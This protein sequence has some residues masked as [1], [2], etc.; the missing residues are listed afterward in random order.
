[1]AVIKLLFFIF[2]MSHE[3]FELD[4][5]NCIFKVSN[6]SA[7]SYFDLS[8]LSR[9]V[10]NIKVAD[11][12]KLDGSRNSRGGNRTLFAFMSPCSSVKSRSNVDYCPD[13]SASVCI[14][15]KSGGVWSR[16]LP[17]LGTDV[18]NK[19]SFANGTLK[20][21]LN[22]KEKCVNDKNYE[23]EILFSCVEKFDGPLMARLSDCS[24][25]VYW[26]TKIACPLKGPD[27]VLVDRCLLQTE[28]ENSGVV[29]LRPLRHPQYYSVHSPD[30]GLFYLN[31]CAT[32][33]NSTC[34]GSTACKHTKNGTVVIIGST[35][36]TNVRIADDGP[37]LVYKAK[38][39]IL[40]RVEFVCNVSVPFGE[41]TFRSEVGNTYTF[42]FQSSHACPK[43]IVDCVVY[44]D[45]ANKFD[46]SNLRRE[47]GNWEVR[48][49]VHGRMNSTFFINVCK[50]LNPVRMC[51]F[52]DGPVGV[53]QT[54]DAGTAI[55]LGMVIKGP[56]VTNGMLQISY[57][58]GSL[59]PNGEGRYRTII[60]FQCTNTKGAPIFESQSADCVTSFIWPTNIA[61]PMKVAKGENCM[62]VEP[63]YSHQFDMTSLHNSKADYVVQT[64][65]GSFRINLCGSLVAPCDNKENISVCLEKEDKQQ[66]A[67]GYTT[68]EISYVNGGIR[69]ELHGDDCIPGESSTVLVL[70]M[71]NHHGYL[72]STKPK[73]VSTLSDSCKFLFIWELQLACPS[74]EEYPCTT[75]DKE[76]NVYDLSILSNPARNYKILRKTDTG[77]LKYLINICR[78]L[79]FSYG[80]TCEYSSGMCEYNMSEPLISNNFRNLGDVTDSLG[81]SFENGVL[82]LQYSN[83][84]MCRDPKSDVGHYSTTITFYC[85]P[86]ELNEPVFEDVVSCNYKFSW[87]TV[88]ACPVGSIH[89]GT[90]PIHNNGNCTAENFYTKHLFDLTSL[91]S[92]DYN[93]TSESGDVLQFSVCRI[94]EKSP[95]ENGTGACILKNNDEPK[96]IS[97]GIGNANLEYRIGALFLNYSE[98]DL[99]DVG[100]PRNTLIEFVC[101]MEN[102]TDGPKYVDTTSN[103]TSMIHWFTQ[104]ACESHVDCVLREG[105][106]EVDLTSLSR[107][108]NSY[109]IINGKSE[110]FINVC[111]PITPLSGLSCPGGSAACIAER[112]LDGSLVNESSLGYPVITPRMDNKKVI[113]KYYHG[114]S[115]PFG[116]E[117]NL[118]SSFVFSCDPK[119][120]PGQPVFNQIED[121]EYQFSWRTKVVCG[122]HNMPSCTLVD[123][124]QELDL[125]DITP[126]SEYEITSSYIMRLCTV[127]SVCNGIV[128]RQINK[129][130]ESL[131]NETTLQ[132]D[133]SSNSLHIYIT[134]NACQGAQ[135][136]N[137]SAHIQ[138]MCSDAA[139]ARDPY[140]MS[141]NECDVTIG[142]NLPAICQIIHDHAAH[143][144]V[145]SGGINTAALVVSMLFI[146]II[147]TLG[148]VLRKQQNRIRCRNFFSC[149]ALSR[150]RGHNFYSK[151][152]SGGEVR[153][154]NASADTGFGES[155]EEMI[156]I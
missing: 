23:T 100:V 79:V 120:D 45:Q 37:L 85:N 130:W 14:A 11:E 70:L 113:L 95:C 66:I 12:R 145:S 133:D 74:H 131:G 141:Q 93:V 76:G 136:E 128:C 78:P 52:K 30:G 140:I 15:Q 56:E 117:V 24:F 47:I 77:M 42:E 137:S 96:S 60:K 110:F 150:Y 38:G 28:G 124:S 106:W 7:A 8:S 143:H 10:W 118:S 146:V 156:R 67:V 35:K 50:S 101:G 148:A 9:Q 21:I 135:G 152:S 48:A 18:L 91:M 126:Q 107:T 112:E 134:G 41:P 5:S 142:W 40:T 109:H 71:C 127:E 72:S 65:V 87:R 123:K 20:V 81:P 153:M 90:F 13:E 53:C 108:E 139:T 89:N 55:N 99:C 19:H 59:C 6:S 31:I 92:K 116:Q 43:G 122:S 57:S 44:D 64:E 75:T 132:Y 104:L 73:F 4:T 154:M 105:D 84:A 39:G 94:L 102:V 68:K 3:T 86:Y 26:P 125:F 114:S 144:D 151:L 34:D 111:A 54:T 155:D 46:L 62:V 49:E 25:T 1:M 33:K 61:C 115:C 17:N 82:T 27:S 32:L 16:E 103:C 119:A 98:G 97:A 69:I 51:N 88:A 80:E 129:T 2:V 63:I 149:F 138:I 36:G 83:G 121:C 58:G 29:D 147:I 22:G